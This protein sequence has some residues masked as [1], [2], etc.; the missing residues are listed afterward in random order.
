MSRGSAQ[1]RDHYEI[2]GINREVLSVLAN[3]LIKFARLMKLNGTHQ[4]VSRSVGQNDFRK[5]R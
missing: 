4:R 2:P 1:I 5:A 3:G